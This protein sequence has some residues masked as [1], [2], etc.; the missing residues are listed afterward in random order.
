MLSV[1]RDTVELPNGKDASREFILHPGA[2]VMVPLFPDNKIILVRQ[3]RYAVGKE[4]LELPA[5]K[6]DF[7]E[8]PL[9][10]A[11][12]ELVEE[13]G[14]YGENFE[15]ISEFFPCIGYADEKMFLYIVTNLKKSQKNTD[16]DEFLEN[17]ILDFDEAVNLVLEGKINDTKTMLSLLLAEKF[18]KK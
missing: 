17:V 8:T 15:L 6:L 5:G 3:F 18:L 14:F 2:S 16:S 4:F 9:E 7:G 11:K 10:T 13:T 1:K 12:R